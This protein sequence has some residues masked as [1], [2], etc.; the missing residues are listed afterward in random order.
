MC[1]ALA[2]AV[3][4]H[5]FGNATRGY[6]ATDSAIWWW[7]S[8]WLDPQAETEH[9]WLILGLSA[10]LFWRNL[11]EEPA[12]PNPPA[13]GA[14]LAAMLGGVALHAVGYGVQQTRVS[15]AGGLL[16]CWGVL[17]LAGGRRWRRAAVFPFGFMLFAIPVNILD[18]AGFWLRLWVIEASHGLANACGIGVIRSGTQLFAP[19]GAYQYDVAA[20]CSGVRSLVALLALSL[21]VGYLNF[22]PAW[23]RALVLLLSLPFTYVGNVVRISAIIVAAEVGGQRAGVIVH[24]WAGFLV[25]VVVLGLVMLAVSGLRRWLPAAVRVD[26]GPA[27]PP[28][29]AVAPPARR[30]AWLV[31]AG[32]ILAAALV[33]LGTRRLDTLPV[34]T[35]TGVRLA[36]DGRNPV[37]L[38]A[39]VGTEWI[40]R[41]VPVSAVELEVLPPDTG[42]SRRVYVALSDP[43]RQVLVSIVLS[44]RDRSSIHRP[45]ICVEGQG[46]TIRDRFPHAFEGV[47]PDGAPLPVSVLRIERTRADGRPQ[48]ML[49]AYWFVSSDAVVATHAERLWRGVRDRLLRGRAD[50]WAYVLAQTGAE[51]GEAAALARL[52]ALLAGTV[53]VVQKPIRA[54]E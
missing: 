53:P 39:F 24:E 32:V 34:R 40:G 18:T 42:Y 50:R 12:D 29:R 25:F 15:L 23:L 14:A 4:W 13:T 3:L 46:W 45:E 47:R 10:W 11:R 19:D 38:P 27:Q 9:G 1:C 35:D 36:A 21:L 8:H 16:F 41:R 28:W 30:H 49:L 6:I 44:G 7:V 5:G 54:N 2:G 51:D 22:R 52:Q 20:A 33:G 26:Q 43:R 48:P 37:D 17:A 31:A